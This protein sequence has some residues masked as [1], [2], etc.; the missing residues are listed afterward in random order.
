MSTRGPHGKFW[1]LMRDEDVELLKNLQAEQDPELLIESPPCRSASIMRS[2]SRAK[3]DPTVVQKEEAEGRHLLKV[4]CD[5]YQRQLDRGKLF[6]HEAPD[7]ADSWKEPCVQ[8]LLNK[9][10]VFQVR[11]PMCRW[12]MMQ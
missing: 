2:L 3:R 7:S 8:T 5:A 12:G 9:D 11:G 4:S 1:D 10:G 6:L